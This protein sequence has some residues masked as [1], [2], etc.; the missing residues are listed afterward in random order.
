MYSI[1]HSNFL[2]FNFFHERL[3]LL[4]DSSNI[5]IYHLNQLAS[6]EKFLVLFHVIAEDKDTFETAVSFKELLVGPKDFQVASWNDENCQDLLLDFG[7]E[8]IE[9]GDQARV[10]S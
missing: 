5:G 2:R 1:R 8:F 6:V 7:V 3:G 10:V 4:D 9:C